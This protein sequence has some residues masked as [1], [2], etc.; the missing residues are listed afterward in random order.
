[1]SIAK[2]L[3][4]G[5]TRGLTKQQLAAFMAESGAS[6]S[7]I[8]RAMGE[9]IKEER[10]AAKAARATQVGEPDRIVT[11]SMTGDEELDRLLK[12][13]PEKIQKKALRPAAKKV[14]KMVL[15]EAIRLCPVRS[16]KDAS[17]TD[18]ENADSK[19]ISG[20]LR[21]QLRL[22]PKRR[23]RKFPHTVGFD[24]GFDNDLFRGPTFYA[25]FL[26]FGTTARYHKRMKTRNKLRQRVADKLLKRSGKF[27]G[28]IAEGKFAFLRPALY[29]D[30]GA[31]RLV[32]QQALMQWIN[33]RKIT[34]QS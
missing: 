4:E 17:A 26:E 1:M 20:S 13:L 30:H 18:A 16:G 23:T 25:G 21:S 27:V 3:L 2:R 10:S 15:Q 22:K 34:L 8:S 14:A 31:K 7:D 19:K 33:K 24:I 9:M 28:L 29:S 6:R 11:M 5:S 32:F 12:A